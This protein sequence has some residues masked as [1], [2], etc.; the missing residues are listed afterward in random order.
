[1]ASGSGNNC[2]QRGEG[3]NNYKQ[4][5]KLH[6]LK[7]FGAKNLKQYTKSGGHKSCVTSIKL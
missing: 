6:A 3:G 4:P 7:T 5:M 2:K 1:M